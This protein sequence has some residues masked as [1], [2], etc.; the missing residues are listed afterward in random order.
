M[1]KILVIDDE[2]DLLEEIVDILTFE[3]YDVVAASDGREGVQMAVQHLPDLVI[4]DI[5]MPKMDGYSVLQELGGFCI[6]P[7]KTPQQL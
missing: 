5:M 6:L 1:A 7:R 2:K 3:G 4:C